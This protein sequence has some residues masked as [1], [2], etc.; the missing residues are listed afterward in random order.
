[1]DGREQELQDDQCARD[2]RQ[3]ATGVVFP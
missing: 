3:E 1:M 2:L